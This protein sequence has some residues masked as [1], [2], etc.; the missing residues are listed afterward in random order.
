MWQRIWPAQ[1]WLILEL[2]VIANLAFLALD[3][4]LAHAINRFRVPSEWLPVV[5]SIA[6][7]LALGWAHLRHRGQGTR[8]RPVG[9]AIGWGAIALGIL[10]T[11]FHLQSQFFEHYTLRSLVYAAPFIA[12][13]AYTGL[14][15]LLLLNRMVPDQSIE[16][17]QWVLM[18]GLGGFG[19]IFVLALADHAQNGFFYPIEWV[20]VVASAYALGFLLMAFFRPPTPAFLNACLGVLALQALIGVVGLLLH[21]EVTLEGASS[22]WLQK[23]IE[24]PPV[25]APL[26]L[27]NLALLAGLG[28]WDWRLKLESFREGGI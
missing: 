7:P 5:Y 18:L 20:P 4:Y 14:G 26:L 1:R 13:L 27:P 22:G 6:A 28:I 19:G 17:S 23:I 8:E 16:W 3:V 2:F 24:G 15:F 11:V 10:G 9:L 25:M 12:P 21:L